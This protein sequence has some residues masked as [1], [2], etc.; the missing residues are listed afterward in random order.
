VKD[1][2]SFGIVIT[3]VGP[4]QALVEMPWLETEYQ[5][6]ESDWMVLSPDGWRAVAEGEPVIWN[7]MERKLLVGFYVSQPQLIVVVGRPV[8]GEGSSET[9]H[10]QRELRRIVHRIRSL[11]LPA[12]VLG[13]WT[14]ED[15]ALQEMLEPAEPMNEPA[16]P[17][18]GGRHTLELVH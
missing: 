11:L 7:A 15:G 1:E 4:R 17:M 3:H 6:D 5:I 10:R 8:D 14:D 18:N 12:G 16:E 2:R 9:E 13:I